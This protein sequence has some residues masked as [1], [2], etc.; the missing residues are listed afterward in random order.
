MLADLRNPRFLAA[1]FDGLGD[2]DFAW[3][4]HTAARTTRKRSRARP[5]SWIQR[6]NWEFETHRVTLEHDLTPVDG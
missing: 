2:D 5:Q 4:F 6:E 1:V 3:R